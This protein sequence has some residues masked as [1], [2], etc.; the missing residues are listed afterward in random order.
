MVST[1]VREGRA[2][3]KNYELTLHKSRMQETLQFQSRGFSLVQQR[4][5]PV[6]SR[7]WDG[8]DLLCSLTP[9]KIGAAP[10]R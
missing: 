5:R 9:T 1:G 6:M 8:R 10:K 7:R 3:K 2:K 4:E